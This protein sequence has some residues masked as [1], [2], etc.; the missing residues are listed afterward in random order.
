MTALGRI[1]E[2]EMDQSSLQSLIQAV[3]ETKITAVTPI[4]MTILFYLVLS[5]FLKVL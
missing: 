4:E 2:L 5:S 3:E 1:Q